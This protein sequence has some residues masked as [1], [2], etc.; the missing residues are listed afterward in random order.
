VSTKGDADLSTDQGVRLG[1]LLPTILLDLWFQAP[2]GDPLLDRLE[3]YGGAHGFVRDHDLL[4]YDPR[5]DFC[6]FLMEKGRAFEAAVL[7]LLRNRCDLVPI[8]ESAQDSRDPDKARETS[9]R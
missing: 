4:G 8:G 6:R 9:R 7:R 5:T 2:L 1:L 3:L